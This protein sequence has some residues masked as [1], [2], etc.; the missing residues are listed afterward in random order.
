[1]QENDSCWKIIYVDD[2]QEP[3]KVND[4]CTKTVH[5]EFMHRDCTLVCP[6][7]FGHQATIYSKTWL[8]Q[9]SSDQRKV[10]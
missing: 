2:V 7:L 9:N 5:A 1:M 3:R 4:T 6:F 10:F 8:I